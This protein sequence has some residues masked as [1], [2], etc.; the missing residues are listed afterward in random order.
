MLPVIF[1][2]NYQCFYNLYF[3]YNLYIFAAP[4]DWTYEPPLPDLV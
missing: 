2:Y 3:I 1:L 4:N